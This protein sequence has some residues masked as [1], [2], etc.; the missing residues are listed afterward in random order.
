MEEWIRMKGIVAVGMSGGVDSSVAAALL[1]QQGY[2]VIGVTMDI[3]DEE[4]IRNSPSGLQG[5]GTSV[6]RHACFGP[7]E[8]EDAER[9]AEVCERLG[10]PHY[11]FDVRAA[12]RSIVL[13]DF[14]SEYRSGR[15]PNPCVRCNSRVKFGALLDEVRKAG[16][17]FDHFATGHYVQHGYHEGYQQ[18]LLKR[19]ADVR[20]DQSYFLYRLHTDQIRTSLFPLGGMV[21][22][23]VRKLAHE[24][25]LGYEHIPESQDF[26]GGDHAGLFDFVPVPGDIVNEEGIVL[27]RHTGISNFTVGQRRGLGIASDRPLYVIRLDAERHQVIVGYEEQTYGEGL[28]ARDM[29]W[30]IE[31]STLIREDAVEIHAKVR[32]QQQPFPV[33][34]SL[35][36]DGDAGSASSVRVTFMHPQRNTSPGQSIVL[37]D[38]DWVLGGGLIEVD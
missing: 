13:D 33:R 35:L 24:M 9:A 5:C 16:I 38:G 30:H 10:I 26:Y 1:V 3:W 21:K 27:G 7:E 4:V 34:V 14:S 29:I 37:Y 23:Q 22:D 28:V 6:P 8:D 32:S 17:E 20:K 18:T 25:D 12:Y 36:T 2:Q 19:A 31:P 15:T 11:R